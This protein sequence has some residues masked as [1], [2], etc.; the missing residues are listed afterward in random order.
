MRV[1]RY[2]APEVEAVELF[3]KIE[4]SW[5]LAGVTIFSSQRHMK[6]FR[7]GNC[8]NRFVRRRMLKVEFWEIK[9]SKQHRCLVEY[10]IN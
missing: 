8:Q 1:L 7:F 3:G 6:V 2:Y 5:L 10:C 9:I 4:G